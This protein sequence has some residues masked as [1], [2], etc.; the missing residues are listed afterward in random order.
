[1][2]KFATKQSSSGAKHGTNGGFSK[3][4]PAKKMDIL[5]AIAKFRAAEIEKP[6]RQMVQVLAGQKQTPAS[7]VKNLGQLNKENLICYAENNT[8]QLTAVGVA[9]VGDM[10]RSSLTNE[11]FHEQV[12]KELISKSAYKILKRI[13]DGRK[14]DKMEV[15]KALKYNLDKISGYEKDLSKMCSLGFLDKQQKSDGILQLTNK[16]FPFGRPE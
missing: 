11:R 8:V 13:S 7:Y 16:C 4:L 9:A 2:A 5:V 14:Y 3:A 6:S 15:A 1:M 10:D 12:L